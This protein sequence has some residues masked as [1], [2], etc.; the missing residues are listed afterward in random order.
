[1]PTRSM[2]AS[3]LIRL[4]LL[5]GFLSALVALCVLLLSGGCTHTAPSTTEADGTPAAKRTALQPQ[6][7]QQPAATAGHPFA[8]ERP[9]TPERTLT[10]NA[11]TTIQY[12][13]ADFYYQ[14]PPAFPPQYQEQKTLFAGQSVLLVITARGFA[15]N[16]ADEADITYRLTLIKPDGTTRHLPRPD[17]AGD[18]PLYQGRVSKADTVLFSR[19]LPLL[20]FHED[21]PSGSYTL[22]ADVRDNISGQEQRLEQRVR[23]RTYRPTALPEGFDPIAWMENYYL[24]PTPELALPALSL[25]GKLAPRTW[26]PHLQNDYT[27]AESRL[28]GFYDRLLTDN[29][30]LLPHFAEA[31]TRAL[32]LP[33]DHPHNLRPQIEKILRTHFRRFS[34]RPEGVPQRLWNQSRLPQFIYG[35]DGAPDV[36]TAQGRERLWGEFFASGGFPPLYKL[37]SVSTLYGSLD[38]NARRTEATLERLARSGQAVLL[39]PGALNSLDRN[40]QAL[41]YT[42]W[43][44]HEQAQKHPQVR[45][46]LL[47][48]IEQGRRAPRQLPPLQ[49][50]DG[51]TGVFDERALQLLTA[52]ASAESLRAAGLPPINTT[53]DS[54]YR[55]LQENHDLLRDSH[56]HYDDLRSEDPELRTRQLLRLDELA[57]A[58]AATLGRWQ[59]QILRPHRI[60]PEPART[61]TDPDAHQ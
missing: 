33:D 21:E 36:L 12:E 46:Y 13:A 61:A 39:P 54:S 28:L 22:V 49:T 35:N 5:R 52:L 24:H 27:N 23:L 1:M 60:L 59:Q 14:S 53:P 15:L 16:A 4:P 8:P 56:D 6:P 47:N 43:S 55:M 38:A 34:K 17:S 3:R 48:I 26:P 58:R 7:S 9:L 50:S 40:S 37:A 42:L 29:P 45:A 57:D 30:W 19:N 11:F 18:N 2:H 25:L 10:A 31:H 51:Q 44:L 20:Y 41:I 32:Y